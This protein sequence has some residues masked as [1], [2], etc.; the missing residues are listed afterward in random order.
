MVSGLLN[1]ILFLR[2]YVLLNTELGSVVIFPDKE[3][4]N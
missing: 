4:R 2:M 3:I 1:M